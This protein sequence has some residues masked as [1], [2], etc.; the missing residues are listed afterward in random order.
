MDAPISTSKRAAIA[1]LILF[2]AGAWARPPR[3]QQTEPPAAPVVVD[4][5]DQPDSFASPIVIDP[6]EPPPPRLQARA[7]VP[8]P[9]LR[10]PR[11]AR[12]TEATAD[13]QIIVGMAT[14]LGVGGGMAL[15]VDATDYHP[16][17][18]VGFLGLSALAPALVGLAVCGVGDSRDYE[19]RCAPAVGGAYIGGAIGAL[20]GALVGMLALECGGDHDG[21]PD[22]ACAA[23]AVIGG[24]AGW[25]IGSV[26][27]ATVGWHNGKRPRPGTLRASLL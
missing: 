24:L 27:G 13:R 9:T 21:N 20:P 8:P 11:P 19:G 15:V 25:A 23:G 14:L 12:P 17:S 5:A 26:V 10:Q 6:A 1:L 3:A 4:P 22:P 7:P 18:L 2:T 16:A